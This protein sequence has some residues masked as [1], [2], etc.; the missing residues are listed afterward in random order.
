MTAEALPL[1]P[2][3]IHL[4][5]ASLDLPE[6]RAAALAASLSRDEH[7]R[8]ERYR[9]PRDRQRYASARGLLRELLSRYTTT[10][11]SELRLEYG[12]RGKP[13]VACTPG[14]PTLHFNLSHSGPL[15]IYAFTRGARVGL[16]LERVR[17]V[18][19]AQRIASRV[20]PPEEMGDWLALPE[21]SRLD[22]F[23]SRWTRL[24]ALAK[25]HGG[26][27]WWLVE[28]GGSIPEAERI[29]VMDLE[30]PEG[31]RAAVAVDGRPRAVREM[32]S[33]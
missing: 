18:P 16:D 12:P 7:A 19:H 23:F 3:E 10:G 24:E 1:A 31:F 27:V 28:H 33:P 6:G 30:A 32:G 22:G 11:A 15:A 9:D 25:L 21:E 2:G 17:E 4:W 29:S 14:S 8:V 20:F 5:R 26:G 13:A